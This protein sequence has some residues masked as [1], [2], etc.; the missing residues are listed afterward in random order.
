M[1]MQDLPIV[2]CFLG[3]TTHYTQIINSLN[4]IISKILGDFF[5][6]CFNHRFTCSF[7]NKLFLFFLNI[8]NHEHHFF[9]EKSALKKLDNIKKDH[10]KR[11]EGLQKE[12]ETDINK[13]RLIE[14]N[15]PLVR[16]TIIK[17]I[18]LQYQWNSLII[19]LSRSFDLFVHHVIQ[20][21]REEYILLKK[22][23]P[24]YKCVTKTWYMYCA[25]MHR[26]LIL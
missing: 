5:I 23:M 4:K 9:Q 19:S 26:F 8:F 3:Q 2:M 7:R 21:K 25:V 16:Y 24:V 15:L 1:Y 17:A 22:T 11:I 6:P 14:L 13:G 20:T 10:E 12:Q 18:A